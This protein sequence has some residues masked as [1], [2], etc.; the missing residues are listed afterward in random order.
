MAT[1]K[2]DFLNILSERGFIHQVSEP[3]V[4]DAKAAAGQITAYIGFDLF[5]IPQV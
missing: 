1:Y 3:D 4:L 5:Q 2:T